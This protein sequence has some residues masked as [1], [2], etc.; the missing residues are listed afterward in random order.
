M[1]AGKQRKY[2]EMEDYNIWC[3]CEVIDNGSQEILRTLTGKV[4]ILIFWKILNI[5]TTKIL[6]QIETGHSSSQTPKWAGSVTSAVS[7]RM[8]L[9][10]RE[11]KNEIL[12]PWIKSWGLGLN[13][14]G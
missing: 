14:V 4:D 3:V 7:Q 11:V 12:L 8:K 6:T 2:T 10:F 1:S 5:G 9:N 13:L